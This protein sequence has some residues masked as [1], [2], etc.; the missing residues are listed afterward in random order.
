[1]YIVNCVQQLYS[2]VFECNTKLFILNSHK[3]ILWGLLDCVGDWAWLI[4]VEFDVL[5]R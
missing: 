1:V 5:I 3:T 4:G 2:E